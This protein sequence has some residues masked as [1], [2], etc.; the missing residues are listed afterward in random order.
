VKIEKPLNCWEDFEHEVSIIFE[1]HEIR[2]K[3][4]PELCHHFPPIFRGQAK[5]WGKESF[6]LKT[7]L[8]RFSNKLYSRNDYY[9][10]LQAIAPAIEGF[11]SKSWNISF[12]EKDKPLPSLEY[13]FMIYLRQHGF[14]SPLLDWTRS[15]YV[16]AFFAFNH[17]PEKEGKNDDNNIVIYLYVNNHPLFMQFPIV[18]L[19]QYAYTHK[20]HF[21]QQCQYTICSKAEVKNHYTYHNHDGAFRS[22]EAE[23][24]ILT[25]FLI[26]RS[27]RL[28]VLNK[29]NLMNINSHSLF[30]TEES[31]MET[32]AY[33]EI[34]RKIN[35]N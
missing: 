19:G 21:I 18:T 27:E 25:K 6:E 33:Q 31:L 1:N 12:D 15:P 22:G 10:I 2:R 16:A 20:R 5:E 8:E 24:D 28:K 29:L 30:G 32:L 3:A 26:P 35:N 34:E 4:S 13:G 11:T 9:Q 23:H 7:T 14:P 17:C